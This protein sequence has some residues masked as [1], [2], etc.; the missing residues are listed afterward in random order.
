MTGTPHRYILEKAGFSGLVLKRSMFLA[1]HWL[2]SSVG[3]DSTAT[4]PRISDG[5]GARYTK[6]HSSKPVPIYRGHP[7]ACDSCDAYLGVL[8]H[9]SSRYA[10]CAIKFGHRNSNLGKLHP[11]NLIFPP[12]GF[13]SPENWLSKSRAKLNFHPRQENRLSKTKFPPPAQLISP[14]EWSRKT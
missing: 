2:V 6:L 1:L 13:I 3:L 14:P 7:D 9:E 8:V 12:E 10:L 11:A 4:S 5:T